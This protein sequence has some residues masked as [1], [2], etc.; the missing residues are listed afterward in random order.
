MGNPPNVYDSAFALSG[1]VFVVCRS[2]ERIHI[3]CVCGE[4]QKLVN[5][6]VF[7]GFWEVKCRLRQVRLYFDIGIRNEAVVT[8]RQVKL[9]LDWAVVL[10]SSC[11][12]SSSIT[13]VCV[14]TLIVA[15]AALNERA[16]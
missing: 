1:V 13:A 8:S 10:I 14:V 9:L 15:V 12:S 3:G 2:S 6:F 16:A 11:V 4:P 5:S 7:R